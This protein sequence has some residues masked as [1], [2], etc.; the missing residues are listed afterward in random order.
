MPPRRSGRW[1][2]EHHSRA[3]VE[4]GVT[5]RQDGGGGVHPLG[6]R[7]GDVGAAVHVGGELL[8]YLGRGQREG[9]VHLPAQQRDVQRG[10]E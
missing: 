4:K 8:P 1:W 10:D 9:E 2:V 7:D 3:A 6:G 5:F